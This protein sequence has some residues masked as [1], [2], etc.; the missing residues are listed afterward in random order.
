MQIPLNSDAARIQ[1]INSLQVI[2][3]KSDDDTII[4]KFEPANVMDDFEYLRLVMGAFI[5]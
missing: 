3:G 1:W 5:A 4:Q 2:E